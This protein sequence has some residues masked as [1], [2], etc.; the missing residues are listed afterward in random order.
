MNI[1]LMKMR[2]LHIKFNEGRIM[3]KK[4]EIILFALICFVM[5]I[6]FSNT[7]VMA[8][9]S[10]TASGYAETWWDDYNREYPKYD[11]DCTNFVS[12]ALEAG[13]LQED[14][15]WYWWNGLISKKSTAEWCNADELR[16]YLVRSKRGYVKNYWDNNSNT[17]FRTPPD[18]TTGEGELYRANVIFYD[19][20]SDGDYDHAG[21][22]TSYYTADGSKCDAVCTHT[23][24]HY[25]VKWHLKPYMSTSQFKKT[26]WV[27]LGIN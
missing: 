15:D 24:A 14:D 18:V 23:S 22:I 20:D 17:G 26:T 21:I 8:F 5:T 12:Q 2:I 7:S 27:G 6:C 4:K 16:K 11:S 9:N 25:R 13:G 10:S 1:H 3:K 19:F